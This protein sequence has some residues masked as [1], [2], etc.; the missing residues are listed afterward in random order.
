MKIELQ[1][2]GTECYASITIVSFDHHGWTG[3]IAMQEG[4]YE[5]GVV[6]RMPWVSI[7][8]VNGSIQIQMNNPVWSNELVE[9]YTLNSAQTRFVLKLRT[10][11]RV[12]DS[13]V[14]L[15][16]YVFMNIQVQN[17]YDSQ[18][19]SFRQVEGALKNNK[20]EVIYNYILDGEVILQEQET[21][22]L[23]WLSPKAK[24]TL[25]GKSRDYVD[26]RRGT[27][28][29]CVEAENRVSDDDPVNMILD[30]IIA[31]TDWCSSL[32]DLACYDLFD[33]PHL[34]VMVP[35]AS[36]VSN[37]NYV[38]YEFVRNNA[39]GVK[40]PVL[41]GV[42][43]NAPFVIGDI[44]DETVLAPY[45]TY[46]EITELAAGDIALADEIQDVLYEMVLG[47]D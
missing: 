2:P 16:E 21:I 20:L 26:Q 47:I 30:H 13:L 4:R 38:R 29:W 8:N 15:V 41:V 6:E 44:E 19:V 9:A 5:W 27:A 40:A 32:D 45:P 37:A 7:Y 10:S 43:L 25:Q 46:A 24:K 11:Y 1:V 22:V 42:V 36:E 18:F 33:R 14:A 17:Q 28:E 31:G 23:G 39:V 12:F 34:Y 3:M 35:R